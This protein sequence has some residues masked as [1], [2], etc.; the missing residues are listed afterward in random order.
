MPCEDRVCVLT[1]DDGLKEQM[2]AIELLESLGASAICYVPTGPVLNGYVLDVHKLHMIRSNL[3]DE[4]LS[5]DLDQ[6]FDFSRFELDDQLL[7]IQYR[8]D[9]LLGRRIKYFLNFSLTHEERK[10]WI[11]EYFHSLFG[12]DNQVASKLYMD[13]EDLV[14]LA[15]KNLLGSHAHTHVPLSMLD[16]K[17]LEYELVTSKRRL[18]QLT[19]Y[20]PIGISYPYGGNSA[21]SGGVFEAAR[22]VGYDYG[23][24]MER[25]VN[26]SGSGLNPM[27]LKR[28]DIN[29][30]SVWL[31]RTFNGL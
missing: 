1:F 13:K 6:R 29:D 25:G 31:G 20:S 24:T 11:E 4:M 26:Y 12:D 23:F 28:I 16:Q 30:L 18:E 2:G 9:S 10:K 5:R 8:Y 3:S 17:H 15:R 14:V 7:K 22:A 19:G 27:A 21:V